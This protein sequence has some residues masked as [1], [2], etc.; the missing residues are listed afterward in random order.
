MWRLGLFF[1]ILISLF[2]TSSVV[3]AQD[4]ENAPKAEISSHQA[5]EAVRGIVPITGSTEVD[6][7]VSWELSFSYSGDTTG[8]W[9]LIS[10]GQDQILDD[11]LTEWDTTTITDGV[12]NLRLSVNLQ[13]GR[14]THF[15]LPDIRVRNYTPIESETPKP[16]QTPTPFTLT[17]LPSKTPSPTLLPTDTPIPDT[18]TPLP[19]NPIEIST[20]AISNSLIRGAGLTITVFLIMGLYANIRKWL[21]D[22]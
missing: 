4:K 22:Y 19:T 5:G 8:T 20:P 6:G 7:F 11:I 10:E 18:P 15:I 12:Y 14:R 3:N 1:S 2:T 13:G 21:R 9:F 17:P 16:S